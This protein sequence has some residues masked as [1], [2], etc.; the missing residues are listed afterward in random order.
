MEAMLK[1]QD[2]HQSNE[3]ILRNSLFRAQTPQTISVKDAVELHK[4]ALEKV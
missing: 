4:E 3:S 2:E 1:S